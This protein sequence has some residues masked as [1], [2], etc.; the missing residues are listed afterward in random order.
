MLIKI[1]DGG[2][3][4]YYHYIK[5]DKQWLLF[6]TFPSSSQMLV[7]FYLSVIHG[8]GFFISQKISLPFVLAKR[9]IVFKL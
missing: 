7:M 1:I 6:S 3:S 2:D 9:V 4:N 8:L 5:P